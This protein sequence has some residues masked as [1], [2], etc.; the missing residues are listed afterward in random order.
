MHLPLTWN[1]WLACVSPASSFNERPKSLILAV[2]L[3]SDVSKQ[4]PRSF[5]ESAAGPSDCSSAAF[6]VSSTF[7]AFRSRQDRWSRRGNMG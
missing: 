1:R 5:P 2:I 3:G 4:L 6:P 7:A